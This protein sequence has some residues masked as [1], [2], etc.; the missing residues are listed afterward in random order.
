MIEQ[1]TKAAAAILRMEKGETLVFTAWLNKPASG[2]FVN[3]QKLKRYLGKRF[4]LSGN[5]GIF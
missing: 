4:I 2:N 1:R 3:I 5:P